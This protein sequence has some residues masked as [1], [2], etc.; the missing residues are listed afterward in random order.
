MTTTDPKR[1]AAEM[2]ATADA[3]RSVRAAL[4]L[5]MAADEANPADAPQARKVLVEGLDVAQ[6]LEQIADQLGAR[7]A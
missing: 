7:P 5:R 1:L 4:Y 2:L 3:L 6:A